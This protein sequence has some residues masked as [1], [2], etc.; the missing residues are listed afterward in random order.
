MQK[1]NKTMK[2]KEYITFFFVSRG[3]YHEKA[4]ITS[5]IFRN[6]GTPPRNEN[7]ISADFP[8]AFRIVRTRPES[9]GRVQNY[10]QTRPEFVPDSS[11]KFPDAFGI[12]PDAS[13]LRDRL[14]T[15]LQNGSKIIKMLQKALKSIKTN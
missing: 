5:T 7:K 2:T 12:L 4:C 10:S 1:R 6:P 9:F 13:R 11:G 8:D 15:R 14:A 3:G